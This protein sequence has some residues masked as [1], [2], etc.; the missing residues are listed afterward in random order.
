MIRNKTKKEKTDDPHVNND[1]TDGISRSTDVKSGERDGR[2][3]KDLSR[4]NNFIA[5]DEPKNRC[6]TTEKGKKVESTEQKVNAKVEIAETCFKNSKL[7]HSSSKSSELWHARQPSKNRSKISAFTTWP[8]HLTTSSDHLTT[9]SDHLTTSDESQ[10]SDA[11]LSN[12]PV[13]RINCSNCHNSSSIRNLS[14]EN[15]QRHNNCVTGNMEKIKEE[16]RK[17]QSF[18][19]T[20]YGE[21]KY[22]HRCR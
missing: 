14:S 16:V 11:R 20:L 12:L 1:E 19:I 13:T 15:K 8:D 17:N 9:S 6:M 18:T 21:R 10:M 2:W 5:T 3:E 22:H 4:R 7:D